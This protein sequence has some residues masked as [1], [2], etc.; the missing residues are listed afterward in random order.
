MKEQKDQEWN[1]LVPL[2]PAIALVPLLAV[3]GVEPIDLGFAAIAAPLAMFPVVLL[4]GQIWNGNETWVSRFKEG[5]ILA[6]SA[7]S[8][9]LVAGLW[10]VLDFLGAGEKK[11]HGDPLT[12]LD[13]DVLRHDGT[14]WNIDAGFTNISFGIWLDPISAMLLFV[15]TFLCFLI[16]WFAIGYMTTDDI[17]SN[18][19]HRFFAEFILFSMGMFGMVLADSFLWL[20]IF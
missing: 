10:M 19:N 15:A 16:C 1:L 20:F 12:W 14:Q 4:I 9:S 17:N 8:V 3:I 2:A 7:L 11:A 18:R 13:F 5:G 6:L